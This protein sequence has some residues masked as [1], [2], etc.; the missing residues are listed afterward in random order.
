MKKRIGVC[1]F[2]CGA[3]IGGHLIAGRLPAV[4]D[5]GRAVRIGSVHERESDSHDEYQFV[6]SKHLPSKVTSG[7]IRK[8]RD[9]V[10][11]AAWP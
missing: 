5:S 2:S 10:N 4:W 7:S 9:P 11:D 6:G 3:V 8:H 1:V